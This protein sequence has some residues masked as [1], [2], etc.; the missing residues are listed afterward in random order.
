MTTTTSVAVDALTELIAERQ[1]F[2]GWIAALDERA[3]T[4]PPH[5]LSRVRGDYASRL[6]TV[7]DRLGEHAP[8]LREAI[9][10]LEERMS[11]SNAAIS[12]REEA[13]LEGELRA[14]VGEYPPEKWQEIRE[15][16]DSELAV[17][18]GERDALRKELDE[19]R[20]IYQQVVPPAD[21]QA[22]DG[23]DLG[24]TQPLR[25]AFTEPEPQAPAA[26]VPG[27]AFEPPPP[28][29]AASSPEA[30]QPRHDDRENLLSELAVYAT[31]GLASSDESGAAAASADAA[32]GDGAKTLRCQECNALNY[33][34]EWYCERCG[35]E[36]ATI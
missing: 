23:V 28:A 31:D 8:D 18:E 22:M 4:V 2:E 7:I 34:T 13:R 21:G 5:I 12:E 14:S 9:A 25:R 35:G 29:A 16:L 27:S 19:L 36:L 15:G 6:R 32:P 30:V 3:D 10:G 24:A 26:G 1:R 33:P 17:L 20:A 11:S